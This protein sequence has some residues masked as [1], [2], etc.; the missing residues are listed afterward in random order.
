MNLLSSSFSCEEVLS[1]LKDMFPTKS[2][3]LNGFHALIYQ[4]FGIL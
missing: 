4:N 2:S 3:G 1:V